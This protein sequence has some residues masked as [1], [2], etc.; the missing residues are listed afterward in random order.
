MNLPRPVPR[1]A[2]AERDGVGR[3]LEGAAVIGGCGGD[4]VV[5]G[6]ESGWGLAETGRA[7]GRVAFDGDAEACALQ[8]MV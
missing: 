1:P 6:W 7:C 5:H 3:V 2:G 8:Q 4:R